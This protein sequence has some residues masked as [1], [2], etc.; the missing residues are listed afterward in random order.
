[1]P[2]LGGTP[3][4]DAAVLMKRHPCH[5]CRRFRDAASQPR[6]FFDELVA[7]TFRIPRARDVVDMIDER[8]DDGH[9]LAEAGEAKLRSEL[10]VVA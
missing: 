1:M 6:Q 3:G 4:E 7:E 5:R 8:S 9:L 2:C 10:P